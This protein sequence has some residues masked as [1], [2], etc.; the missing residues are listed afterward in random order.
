[1]ETDKKE[2]SEI[3]NKEFLG[4][5]EENKKKVMEMTK[6]LVLTQNTIVPEM[7]NMEREDINKGVGR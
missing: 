3:L 7:L 6:F 5:T 1:V 4:L 2:M